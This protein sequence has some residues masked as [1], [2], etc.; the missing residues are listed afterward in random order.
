[1]A[2]GTPVIVSDRSTLP[3][4]VGDAGIKIDAND[5]VMLREALKRLAEDEGYWQA[6]AEASLR[7]AAQFS[8]KRC[9]EETLAVY[10]KVLAHTRSA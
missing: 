6:R 8:W 9:A 3:E 5:V 7:Q 4:V 1:M 10:R 2:S